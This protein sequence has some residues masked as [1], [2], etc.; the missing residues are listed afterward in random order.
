MGQNARLPM[1]TA[2]SIGLA[3]QGQ[4]TA[5]MVSTSQMGSVVLLASD[6]VLLKLRSEID[7]VLT[8]RSGPATP[9]NWRV[10]FSFVWLS[11]E[12]FL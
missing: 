6:D 7:R 4:E 11:F 5:L 2:K 3:H 1:L 10:L 9:L 12:A 8:F